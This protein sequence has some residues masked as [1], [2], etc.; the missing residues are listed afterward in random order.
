MTDVVLAFLNIGQ[1]DCT[2]AVD[3][4]SGEGLLMD[5]PP[6]RDSQVVAALR[7]FGA[8]RLKL[9]IASHQHLDHLGG[10]YAIATSF[11]TEQVSM[12]QATHVPADA[13]EAKKLR[14]TLRA[15]RG[16]QRAGVTLAE[17]R[18]GEHGAVGELRW[19]ILA[20]DFSQ[21][22]HAQ[23]TSDANHASVVIKISAAGFDVL[24]SA[25]ADAASWEAICLR[26][27]NL[28]ADVLQIPHHGGVMSPSLGGMS[29]TKLLE[30][31]GA[32]THV[33]S[34]GSSNG[35][36]HPAASTLETLR[37]H[38]GLGN[39]LCT[40]LNA[41]CAGCA[42]SSNTGCAG[43]IKFVITT[44][45]VQISPAPSTHRMAVAALPSAQCL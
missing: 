6:G 34:V 31:V 22:L 40:Q 15:I 37:S 26:E 43:N 35:Y 24:V 11:P 2:V 36:G 38:V 9:V 3:R 21:L 23:A 5:C 16:L 42:V 25:D 14:A 41:I 12:N 30:I 28:S 32:Q 27:S 17:P 1:G 39:L 20:P 13:S 4:P 19:K 8:T 10:I 45:G 7:E 44:A 33:I 29:L 18:A